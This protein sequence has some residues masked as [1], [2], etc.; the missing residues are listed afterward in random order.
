MINKWFSGPFPRKTFSFV[1]LPK[2]KKYFEATYHVND[3]VNLSKLIFD[4]KKYI[5]NEYGQ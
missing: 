3:K 1:K 2:L 5:K 4:D